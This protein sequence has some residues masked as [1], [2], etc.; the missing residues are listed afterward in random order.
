[1]THIRITEH[2]EQATAAIRAQVAMAELADFFS[3]AFS[4]TMAVLQK[5]GV[6]PV[7]P[8][9]GK[10]YGQPGV[11]V[12][13]EAGFPVAGAIEPAGNVVPG[14]LPAGRVVEATH[15]GPFDTLASTYADVES[16]FVEHKLKPS[17]VMWENYLADPETE[18]SPENA[19]TQI[20][21][22]VD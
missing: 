12:D 19:R 8:P 1:M 3:H 18:Q 13:V 4:D 10:Y 9:F 21:W 7:G 6:Q 15:I 14:E 20:C 2:P 22:P 16:F 17:A 11:Q 5:Q